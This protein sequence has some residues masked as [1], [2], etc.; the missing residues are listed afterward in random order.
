M[1]S[2]FLYENAFRVDSVLR[3]LGTNLA[4]E[5]GS[6]LASRHPLKMAGFA[7][8]IGL[9]GPGILA[10]FAENACLQE[11]SLDSCPI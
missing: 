8:L 4:V 11:K 1:A 6:R 9:D 7:G 2:I 5:P 3:H 10:R